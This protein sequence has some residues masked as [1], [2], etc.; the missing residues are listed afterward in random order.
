M[1]A[2]NTKKKIHEKK[3]LRKQGRLLSGRTRSSLAL[4]AREDPPELSASDQ[5]CCL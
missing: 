2:S 5:S 4:P 1:K 3:T